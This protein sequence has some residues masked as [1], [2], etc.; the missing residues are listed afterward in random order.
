MQN[1]NQPPDA[2]AML[3]AKKG[4][5]IEYNERIYLLLE[6]E[7]TMQRGKLRWRCKSEE[8]TGYLTGTFRAGNEPE[9]FR[10]IREVTA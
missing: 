9:T 5:V 3:G 1:K 8:G 2:I 6:N 7:P 4:D 10:L